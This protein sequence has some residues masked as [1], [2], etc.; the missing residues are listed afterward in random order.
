[1]TEEY[2]YVPVVRL[3]KRKSATGGDNT[4]DVRSTNGNGCKEYLVSETIYFDGLPHGVR[5]SDIRALLQ[6]CMPNE[7]VPF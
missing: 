1:M 4:K 6:H 2:P 7:Y 3:P 5:D